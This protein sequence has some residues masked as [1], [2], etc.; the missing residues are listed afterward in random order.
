MKWRPTG[1][2]KPDRGRSLDPCAAAGLGRFQRQRDHRATEPPHDERRRLPGAVSD[3]T[4]IRFAA[5]SGNQTN[6]SNPE[7]DRLLDEARVE[8]DRERRFRIYN[9]AEQMVL[10]DAPW[11]WTWFS[12]EGY[13]LIQPEV[14]GYILTQMPVPKYRYV[15]FARSTEAR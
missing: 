15:Y 9:R 10:D 2:T 14:S 6:Y 7:V 11:V 3:P 1:G 13:V 5:S 4:T 8:R 12:G